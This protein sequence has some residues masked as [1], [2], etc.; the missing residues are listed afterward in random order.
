MVQDNRIATFSSSTAL[1]GESTLTW[2]GSDYLNIQSADGVEGGIRL[3]K[4]TTDG[5]HTQYH[6]SHRDDNQS[7]IIYSYDGTTFRNWI[8]LDEPNALLKLGSNSSNLV[9]INSS[10]QM[11]DFFRYIWKY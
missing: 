1:N 11:A 2:N 4:S 8:T 7:L 9:T 10:A 3:Q 5:T 6:I